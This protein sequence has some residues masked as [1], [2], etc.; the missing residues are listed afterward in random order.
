MAQI[1]SGF[2]LETPVA[3]ILFNRPHL[4]EKVF[5]AVRRAKPR[6]LFL[7]AD[8]PHCEDEV[9][10]CLAARSLAEEVDWDCELKTNY[11]EHN[12]GC[13]QRVVSGLNWLFSLAEEAIILEDD[14]VP[15]P[16]FFRYCETL[17]R[18]YRTDERV[19]EISGC[20][21]YPRCKSR[22]H[23]YFFSHYYHTWGWAT[24]R[25]AWKHY[26]VHL[27][28]WPEFRQSQTW[29]NL[30]DDA[31]EERFWAN[32]YDQVVAGGLETSWDYQWQFARWVHN[33]LAAVPA[34]NLV[35]N[36][37]FGPGATTTTLEYDIRARLPAYDVGEI[38]H[39]SSVIRDVQADRY[40]FNRIE[41]L[42]PS[43]FW[44][45]GTRLKRLWRRVSVPAAAG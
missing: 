11:A 14:C 7:I 5:Q 2:S 43:L 41:L 28:G 44:R 30:F 20:N 3:I 31:A 32:V 37:G 42:R 4:V 36:I 39:P 9:E 40:R 27:K 26:D 24:W 22:W 17:L 23:S 21:Y 35:T 45:A 12:L 13:R 18:Y 16:S 34:V 19:M 6:Q 8:G 15:H 1:A 10:Q 38:H 29:T 25:R 33:G